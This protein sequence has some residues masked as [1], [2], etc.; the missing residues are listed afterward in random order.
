VQSIFDTIAATDR[1]YLLDPGVSYL[2]VDAVCTGNGQNVEFREISIADTPKKNSPTIVGTLLQEATNVGNFLPV[3]E[4]ATLVGAG[5]A[6]NLL[7]ERLTPRLLAGSC[8]RLLCVRP[9]RDGGWCDLTVT[10]RV[11]WC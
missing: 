10:W 3:T 1:I 5:K 9:I 4:G 2:R 6:D 7:T 11:N 8:R